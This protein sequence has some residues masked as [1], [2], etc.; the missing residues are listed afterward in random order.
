MIEPALEQLSLAVTP[1]R[2]LGTAAWQSAPALAL[3]DVGQV[4][5]GCVLS[6]TVKLVVQEALLPAV[7]VAVTVIVCMPRLTSISAAGL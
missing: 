1:L 6:V 4:T 3:L 7:S 5:V 2:M